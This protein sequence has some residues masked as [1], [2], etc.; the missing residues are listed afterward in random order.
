MKVKS[1]KKSLNRYAKEWGVELDGLLE[2]LRH[3]N[4]RDTLT[5]FLGLNPDPL[6][7]FLNAPDDAEL[8]TR[9]IVQLAD[10][11]YEAIPI[12][13]ALLELRPNQLIACLTN[14]HADDAAATPN[15]R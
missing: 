11:F 3:P 13:A 9:T 10:F 1:L 14:P 6:D 2:H 5:E 15:L 4:W 7:L 12:Y 8:P